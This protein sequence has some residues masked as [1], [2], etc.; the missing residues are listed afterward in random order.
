MTHLISW[1]F[2]TLA[3]AWYPGLSLGHSQASS[4]NASECGVYAFLAAAKSLNTQIDID[5]VLNGGYVSTIHG[6]T[7]RDLCNAAT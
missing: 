7:S 5:A 4:P 6:S 2:L 1:Y 3:A